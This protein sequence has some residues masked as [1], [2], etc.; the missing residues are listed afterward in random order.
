MPSGLGRGRGRGATKKTL[1][2]VVVGDKTPCSSL[3]DDNEEKPQQQ[4]QNSNIFITNIF[5]KSVAS[6]RTDGKR[7]DDKLSRAVSCIDLTD[8]NERDFNKNHKTEELIQQKTLQ[9]TTVNK[10]YKKER[11]WDKG[12]FY[13]KDSGL[14]RV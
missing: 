14:W 4:K 5:R 9:E 11:E 6:I 1:N 10:K 8:D 2:I 3:T 13:D 12:K 7:I